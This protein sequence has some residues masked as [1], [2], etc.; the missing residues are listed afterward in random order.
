MR[1]L[2]FAFL[3]CSLL[4]NAQDIK[5][6]DAN[7]ERAL[8]ER[9]FDVGNPDGF[10]NR[11]TVRTVTFLDVSNESI[12]D[13]TG[14]EAFENLQ[15]LIADNNAIR[16]LD[17]SAN[18]QI[19]EVSMYNNKLTAI[20]LSQNPKLEKLN[21]FKN[22]L[23]S[24]DLT[25][26]RNLTYLA[27]ADN[28]LTE[29]NLFNN[30]Q[31]QTL[32]C[33]D[34]QLSNLNMSNAP[35]LKILNC[36]Y[37]N[38]VDLTVE[39]DAKLEML[40]ASNNNLKSLDVSTNA[41]LQQINVLY[42]SIVELDL[43]LNKSL[44]AILVGYNSLT[45]LNIRNGNN[46]NIQIFRAE[47]NEGLDCITTDDSIADTNAENVTGRWNK[48][49]KAGYAANC[50]VAEKNSIVERSFSFFVGTD[51]TLTIN[52]NQKAS[53]QILNLQGVAVIS[54]NLEEGSNAVN[55]YNATSDVYVLQINS[56]YGTYTKKFILN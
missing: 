22:N 31:L 24:I 32:Y 15:T 45:S 36:E 46:D 47:G 53:L 33:Q 18:A 12:E 9:G 27:V 10:I 23:G 50:K 1:Q 51:K 38:I 30:R 2:Y 11:T 3:L 44:T 20:N 7:F 48:D 25:N 21:T 26:N 5:I 52:S 29:L 35:E 13:L 54:K 19:K 6:K 41:S 16:Q 56:E 17:L 39:N 55:L 34:N 43:S 8:I 49:Y 28:N 42:N 4:V 37:N 40:N 14:I